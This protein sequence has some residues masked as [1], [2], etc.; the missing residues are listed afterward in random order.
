MGGAIAPFIEGA[1]EKSKEEQQKISDSLSYAF[2]IVIN[3]V[4]GL[5]AAKFENRCKDP[6]NVDNVVAKRGALFMILLKHKVQEKGFTVAHVKTDSIKIPNATPE[7]IQFVM[8]FGKE[9][10]YSFEHEATYEKMCL[11]N[12]SVY[13][14]KYDEFG[15]RTKGGKH[16]NQ[17]SATGAEF[18]HPYIFK[19]LFSH[20]PITFK[21]YCE[22]KST[23]GGGAIYLDNNEGLTEVLEKELYSLKEEL[24]NADKGKMEI[25]KRI[26]AKQEE[27]DSIHSFSFVGKC[28]LF[29][30]VVPG[31]GGGYLLRVDGDKVGAI[32]GTK[33]Y[34][35][36]ESVTVKNKHLED[37]ID[38]NYF[39]SL[40]DSAIDHI[41]EYG[42]AD[43][44]ING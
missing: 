37:K 27:I 8:D 30:P 28:G 10:G 5:T 18:Q 29:T 7:I 40:V 21:D 20:E 43:E 2:K 25:K 41:A 35:W 34:R 6:R 39:R 23:F 14:C 31:V 44:F 15:E 38:M 24:N 32:S 3:S 22:T 17:W 13:I 36:M 33:G 9:Y 42:D 26:K 4:F 16:A 19:T 11:V 12:K 1:E